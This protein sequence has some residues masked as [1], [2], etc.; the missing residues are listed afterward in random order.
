MGRVFSDSTGAWGL[1]CVKLRG[2]SIFR[3][4]AVVVAV[5]IYVFN[6][7]ACLVIGF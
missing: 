3:P 4:A 1:C 7:H 6:G 2:R 5:F